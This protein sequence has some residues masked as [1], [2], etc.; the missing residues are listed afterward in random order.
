MIRV[1]GKFVHR[2]LID[3]DGLQIWGHNADNTSNNENGSNTKENN[4][5]MLKTVF[6]PC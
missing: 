5:T 2:L 4:G 1:N 3:I 6:Q